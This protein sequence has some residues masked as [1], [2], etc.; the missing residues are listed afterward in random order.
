[1]WCESCDQHT[2]RIYRPRTP[3]FENFTRDTK[4]EP[5]HS[6]RTLCQ[7]RITFKPKFHSIHLK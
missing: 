3:S 2:F 5:K 1:M 6:F 7:D 4:A